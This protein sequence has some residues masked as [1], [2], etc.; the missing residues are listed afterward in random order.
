MTADRPEVEAAALPYEGANAHSA[1]TIVI[2]GAG[3]AGGWAAQALR[4][5]GFAGRVVLIGDEAHPPHERG[6][7]LAD[8]V[9]RVLSVTIRRLHPATRPIG[10]Q[11][12]GPE[13]EPCFQKAAV[14][15]QYN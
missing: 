2:V 7:I 8:Q 4:S 11:I 15:L 9:H 5:E 1:H 14:S 10:K 6:I 13:A 3:Q 12:G